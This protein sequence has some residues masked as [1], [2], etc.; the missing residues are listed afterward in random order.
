MAELIGNEVWSEP[1]IIEGT[2][3]LI[4]LTIDVPHKHA[5]SDILKVVDAMAYPDDEVEAACR[6]FA[7]AGAHPDALHSLL[8]SGRGQ[9]LLLA[10][11]A[12]SLQRSIDVTFGEEVVCIRTA[13][14]K[15]VEAA[16]RLDQGYAAGHKGRIMSCPG[17][18]SYVLSPQ[19]FFVWVRFRWRLL[20]APRGHRGFCQRPGH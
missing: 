11:K 2:K 18:V 19:F 1:Q 5:L 6:S 13:L 10:A 7:Q 14:A 3:G 8:G 16:G 4:A 15:L 17:P 20:S 12:K 9:Q